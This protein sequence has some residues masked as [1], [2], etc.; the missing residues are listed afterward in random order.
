MALY[1]VLIICIVNKVFGVRKC[2]ERA[3]K[4]VT[5]FKLAIYTS[6]IV[7]C[8]LQ[9][10]GV[11]KLNELAKIFLNPNKIF[12]IIR[13]LPRRLSQYQIEPY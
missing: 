1:C 2:L 6:I 3:N 8:L 11:S 13:W 5:I 10:I 9:T 4:A 7:L 12:K